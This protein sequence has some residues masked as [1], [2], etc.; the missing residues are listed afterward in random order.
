[1]IQGTAISV[2]E[3]HVLQG[4]S[5]LIQS[6]FQTQKFCLNYTFS[7]NIESYFHNVGSII[8][9]SLLDLGPYILVC[10]T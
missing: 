10:E 1:M 2:L 4:G 7:N 9:N 5:Q 3:G 6:Y 8:H